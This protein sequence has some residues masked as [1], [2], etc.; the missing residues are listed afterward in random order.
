MRRS[1]EREPRAGR[2]PVAAHGWVPV[3]HGAGG[4]IRRIPSFDLLTDRRQ[5]CAPQHAAPVSQ[6]P[7]GREYP[8]GVHG[9]ARSSERTAV[10]LQSVTAA[11]PTPTRRAERRSLGFTIGASRHLA[12]H[13]ALC[14]G[15]RGPG[16]TA[17][18]SVRVVW[19]VKPSVSLC[20]SVCDG[21]KL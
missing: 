2:R 19:Y 9:E 5:N 20:L 16:I 7:Q 17:L 12:V 18:R 1:R 4:R 13:R 8:S 10:K 11:A 21:H 15:V 6:G 14:L 3:R